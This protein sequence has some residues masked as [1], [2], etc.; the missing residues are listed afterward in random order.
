MLDEYMRAASA[1][2]K[3]IVIDE[4]GLRTAPEIFRGP[5]LDEIRARFFQAV[6][7]EGRSKG[8]Q[9][10][11]AWNAL[12]EIALIPN[13]YEVRASGE[14]LKPND[15]P[16]IDIDSD[17]TQHRILHYKSSYNL[18]E[19]RGNESEPGTTKTSD[20]LASSWPEYR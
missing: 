15:D 9:G 14:H 12:P 10:L 20:V 2:G 19:W 18:F 7:A 5:Q 4:F 8:L 6:I 11:L 1:L 13:H 17:H 3:P 16:E